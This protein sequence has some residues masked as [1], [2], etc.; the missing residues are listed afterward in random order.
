M[1]FQTSGDAYDALVGR[2]SRPLAP[3]FLDFAAIGE[4][5]VLDVGCGPGSLTAA[6]ASRIGPTSV[7]AVDPSAPFVAACRARVPGAAVRLGSAEALPF[8]DGAFGGALSQLVLSFVA[9]ADATLREMRRVVR[10]GGVLAA[11]TWDAEGF[12]MATT[13][14]RGATRIVPDA[15]DDAGL[16]F[17]RMPELVALWQRGGAGDVR[18]AVLEVEVRYRDFDDYWIPF[19]SGVG[20]P[21]GWLVAQ[22]PERQAAV[23]EACREVLGRPPGP[24]SLRGRALAIRGSA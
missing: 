1:S 5:P 15:P 6:M 22:P 20:P 19:A 23:R 10:P 8:G 2:Y 9:D 14:W 4:G 24:F 12:G 3:L 17:R 11:C 16:P 13:F 21:G 18:T 7:A